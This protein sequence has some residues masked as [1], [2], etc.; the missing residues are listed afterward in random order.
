MPQEAQR[1][2]S[3]VTGA[4]EGWV[5]RV[6]TG[7]GP[8]DFVDFDGF[9]DGA[10]LEAKGPGYEE[11]LRK[12]HGKR[13]FNGLKDMASQARRQLEAAHDVPLQ[14]HFAEREVADRLREV[15]RS[16]GASHI[17]VIH[18]PSAP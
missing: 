13:W 14:W 4:P 11:L 5:Y 8:K 18:T 1:Y 6:R 3:Q 16:Q 12:M 15:L 7:L 9:R 2:Q 10:L 17:Q